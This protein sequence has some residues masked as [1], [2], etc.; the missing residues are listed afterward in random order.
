MLLANLAEQFSFGV[1]TNIQVRQWTFEHLH[2]SLEKK[3]LGTL[4]YLPILVLYINE[5][6][7]ASCV[8]E[9]AGMC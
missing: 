8:F 5:L 7:N 3:L 6:Q 9:N 2:Q 4:T 1:T